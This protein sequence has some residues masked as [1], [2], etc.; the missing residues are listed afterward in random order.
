MN[1]AGH[2]VTDGSNNTMWTVLG[3]S[4][5]MAAT[6]QREQCWAHRYWWQQQHDMNGAGHT[7]T[8]DSN[9]TTWTVLGTPLLM[10]ATTQREQCW[11]HRHWWQQHNVNSAGHT[12]TDGSDNTTWTVLGTP[13]LMAEK[14]QGLVIA[15]L[16]SSV[17]MRDTP[18]SI[19]KNHYPISHTYT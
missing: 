12:V 4:L 15:V 10:A 1:S 5:L 7:V 19:R 17:R 3:T 2:T 16:A 11:A 18:K 14:S 13:L 8:D 6:T 9:N